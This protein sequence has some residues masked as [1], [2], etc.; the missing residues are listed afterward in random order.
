MV[1]GYEESEFDP[2]IKDVR[3]QLNKKSSQITS[4]EIN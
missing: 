2:D 3:S 1:L 4:G